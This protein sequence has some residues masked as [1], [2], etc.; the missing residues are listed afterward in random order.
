MTA[1]VDTSVLIDVLRDRPG[2]AAMLATVRGAGAVHASEI[3]RVEVL[4]GMRRR[5]E[6]ATRALLATLTWVPLDEQVAERAAELGRTWLM[7]HSGIDVAD[8]VIAATADLLGAEL[9][10]RNVKHFPMFDGLVAPY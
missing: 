5:E 1:L 7:S 2:A 10:T 3:T 6:E 9:L 8:L 4:S